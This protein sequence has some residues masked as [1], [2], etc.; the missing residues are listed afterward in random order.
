MARKRMI[1]PS[2]W[3]DEKLGTVEPRVRLLFMGL[4]SQAD[5]EGRLNGHPA[6]I[7]SLIYAYDYDITVAD[8]ESW[9]SLLAERSLILRYEVH[10]QKY[11]SISNFKK[12]Q[13]INRPQ[14]SKLPEPIIEQSVNDQCVVTDASPTSHAQY[15]LREVKLSED[16]GTEEKEIP[17]L[18]SD[19]NGHKERI[20]ILCNQMNIQGFTTYILDIVYS[21]IGMADIEVI[22]AAI[23]KSQNKPQTYLTNTLNGMI[24]ND[25]I[26]KAEQLLP[27]RG[28]RNAEH[29]GGAEGVQP[30][31]HSNAGGSRH[32]GES[33][34]Y[35][36]VWDDELPMSEV[37]G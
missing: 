1:D 9:L 10:Q 20:R 4:I 2:F 24:N 23:K 17:A 33:K 13:T 31:R 15:N 5:D 12:H 37:S 22:E 21:Y 25:R 27:V 26:T 32:E 28:G 7:R 35:A 18:A 30:G 8:I 11:I 29:G 6:L 3:V 16:K 34:S 36:S 19:Q 14:V